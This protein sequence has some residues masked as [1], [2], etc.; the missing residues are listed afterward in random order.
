M[1][2][3]LINKRDLSTASFDVVYSNNVYSGVISSDDLSKD[4]ID[5]FVKYERMQRE[6][7]PDALIQMEQRITEMGIQAQFEHTQPRKVIN[8]VI[9]PSEG[10]ISFIL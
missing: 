9:S 2:G 4:I 7:D 5:L 1:K 8:L 6:H 10:S 3:R